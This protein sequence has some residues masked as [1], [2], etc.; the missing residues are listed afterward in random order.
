MT[1]IKLCGLTRPEDI[2]VVNRLQPD[3]CGFIIEFSKSFRSITRKQV[4]ALTEKLD[5]RI[6]AVGVFVNAPPELPAALLAEGTIA[7]AQLHGQEDEA[8]IH[9]LRQ[10]TDGPLIKAF[11]V[12]TAEDVK[13]AKECSADYILLDQGSGGTGQR[14]DWSL[15]EGLTRPYFLAGGLNPANLAE[16][17]K[18][19]HPWAVDLS[20]G[21][22]TDR[23]KDP[24]K[25]EQAV[26]IVRQTT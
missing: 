1:K 21:L 3:Y 22:E 11:S 16:A 13:G 10:L 7:L 9:S 15:T 14:F 18:Q 5:R 2:E 23:L 26:Q 8:Y 4:R 19:L 6:L 24:A 17:I 25:M 12:K 20:S